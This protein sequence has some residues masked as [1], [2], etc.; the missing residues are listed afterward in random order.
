MTR[1]LDPSTN[2]QDVYTLSGHPRIEN[3]HKPDENQVSKTS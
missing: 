2:D 1:P 3:G